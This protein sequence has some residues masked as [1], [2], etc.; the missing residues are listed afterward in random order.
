[1]AGDPGVGWYIKQVGPYFATVHP[2]ADK[3]IGVIED[4]AVGEIIR[5]EFKNLRDAKEEMD[6][7]LNKTLFPKS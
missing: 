6:V 2:A 5:R 7:W 4:E 1:M 3:W